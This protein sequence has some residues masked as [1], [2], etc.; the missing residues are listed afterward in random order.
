MDMDMDMDMDADTI[1]GLACCRCAGELAS[2]AG[3]LG[4]RVCG[5]TYPTLGGLPC[6]MPEPA[7][8]RLGWHARLGEYD[9][10][11]QGALAGISAE[12]DRD[13][14][15]ARTRE[16]LM[17]L[18]GG[19]QVMRRSVGALMA[20][21]VAGAELM[22]VPVFPAG[23]GPPAAMSV[24]HHY[25]N[26]FRDWAWGD[27]ENE[28]Q[29]VL[30]QDLI[31][32]DGVRRLAIYGAGA[33]RLAA[34][35]HEQIAPAQTFALDL[36]PLPLIVAHQLTRGNT[37][38]L[39]E[40][41]VAPRSEEQVAVFHTL[42]T[43][44]P[45]AGL[46]YLFANALA[47]PFAPSSLDVVVTPWFIDV[48]GVELST[49][50]AAINRVLRPGGLWLNLG[51]LLFKG[52]I[53]GQH[54]I[55]ETLD[56]V[57]GSGFEV[58]ASGGVEAPYF[59]SPHS[60]SWRVETQYWFSASKD[61]DRPPL[62]DQPTRLPPWLSDLRLSVPPLPELVE[63][64]RSSLFTIGVLS[65]IDGKRSIAEMATELAGSWGMEA[66]AVENHLGAF[67]STFFGD[68]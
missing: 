41:P 1:A 6:L 19:M 61:A 58:R 35:L 32:R 26:I 62:T 16:R 33:G 59:K 15:L 12:R 52:S 9:T 63:A 40:L 5:R 66:R 39:V 44:R 27:A 24:L 18:A 8:F 30:V 34:D 2:I 65:M 54:A 45:R 60:A 36:N 31:P 29:R 25:E 37:L 11:M 48:V 38:E 47:P 67:F 55:G 46:T 14:L 7:V 64:H 23:M 3:G 28:R 49:T 53:S 51:P 10:M 13:D 68:P 21:V 22:P 56:I 17:R 57:K 50:A 20:P 43:P 4:C 42:G